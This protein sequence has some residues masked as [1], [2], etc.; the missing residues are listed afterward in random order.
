M[1][2]SDYIGSSSEFFGC[3]PQ[4]AFSCNSKSRRNFATAFLVHRATLLAL[5]RVLVE[6]RRQLQFNQCEAR[7]GTAPFLNAY[8]VLMM[9]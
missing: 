3:P 8:D 1:E 9:P 2:V 7:F 4:H 6:R 5:C